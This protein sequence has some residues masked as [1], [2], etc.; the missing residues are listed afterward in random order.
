[1]KADL[2]FIRVFG[3]DPRS[4]AFEDTGALI[5]IKCAHLRLD[6]AWDQWVDKVILSRD[7]WE[8]IVNEN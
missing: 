6:D 8:E 5:D 1:L 4:S 7:G 3:P 2:S